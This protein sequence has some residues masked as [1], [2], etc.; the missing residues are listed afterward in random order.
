MVFYFQVIISC[1]I[2]SFCLSMVALQPLDSNRLA[3]FWGTAQSV[4]AYW[5]PSPTTKQSEKE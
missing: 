1:S 5:L 3:L 4:L 2:L